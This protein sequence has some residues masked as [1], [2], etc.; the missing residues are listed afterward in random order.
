MART[1][2]RLRDLHGMTADQPHVTV[3]CLGNPGSDYAGTRHNAGFM[4]ADF[5]AERHGGTDFEPMDGVEGEAAQI[6]LAGLPC[7]LVKPMT[8]MNDCGRVVGPL[9]E[10]FGFDDNLWAIAHDDLDLSLGSVKGRQGGGHGGHNGV[11]SVLEAAD[12]TD[13]VR[14]KLGVNAASRREYDGVVDFLLSEFQP[15]ERVTLEGAFG[16]AEE[17]LTGQVKSFA[18]KQSKR[19]ARREAADVYAEEVLAKAREAVAEVPAASPWAIFLNSQQLNRAVEVVTTLAKL[20]RKAK[21]AAGHDR[22]FYDRLVGFI[23]EPLRPLLPGPPEDQRLFF[24]ADLHCAPEGMKVIELNCAVGYG[25]YAHR[26][27]QVLFPLVCECVPGAERAADVDFGPFLYQHGLRPLHEPD[28]GCIA[29]L[30]GF[31]DEDMFNVDELEGLADGI[32]SAGGLEIPLCHEA[33]LKLREDGL[34]LSGAGRV[35][36]LYVEENLSEWGELRE[37]SPLRRAVLEGTVK[38]F[39]ALDMFLYTNKGFLSVLCDPAAR[40]HL[41]PDEEEGKV[42]RENVLW[43]QVLDEHIE[44]A[45]YYMLEQGLRLA[46]KD[47]LGGGGRGVTILRPESSSQQAGHILQQRLRAGGSVVQGYF[48]P[49][50][51]SEE[52]D[53]R[54]DVRVV[55]SAHRGDVKVGPIYGR[56]FS[57][58]KLSLSDEDAGVAPVY[59]VG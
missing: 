39:P 1:E 47:Y 23:P 25:H 54:F 59:T 31:N 9:R 7:L 56:V 2:P 27:D 8:T 17:V 11:R 36:L 16:E 45:A 44:P 26:A 21:A 55:A 37:D 15:D 53:L 46:V 22:D 50:R 34:H 51:L 3:I 5:L 52:S 28:A 48:E 12:R 4:F 35:D 10:R 19:D 13:I 42:L 29:F 57:G 24:A 32:A 18:A 41:R 6:E 14:I 49:G 20:L 38:T 58:S 33:D 43:S 40:E 30:R